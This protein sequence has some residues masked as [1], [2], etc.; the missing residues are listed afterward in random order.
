MIPILLSLLSLVVGAAAVWLW[1]YTRAIKGIGE[2][3]D[4]K[5][6]EQ[7]EVTKASEVIAKT[8]Q[9]YEQKKV[10]LDGESKEQVYARIKLRL[11]KSN[12]SVRPN[13]SSTP[14]SNN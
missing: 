6:I 11:I 3:I 8:K 10:E 9:E 2:S 7:K 5:V 4:A 1:S 14:S 12:N 13:S